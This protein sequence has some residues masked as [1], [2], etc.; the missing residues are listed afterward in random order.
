[1]EKGVTPGTMVGITVERSLEMI[2]GILGILKAG[3]A[4]VPLNPKAPM[5]RNAYILDE[6]QF[7]WRRLQFQGSIN[8]AEGIV[9]V[10]NRRTEGG[11]KIT[12]LI[13]NR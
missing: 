12:A 4:Y 13:A 2:I 9:V 3:C 10:G 7:R 8:R 5:K 6:I 1:M 11:V